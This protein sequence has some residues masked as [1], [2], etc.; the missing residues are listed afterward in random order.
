MRIFLICT[1]AASF[2]AGARLCYIVATIFW[3][4]GDRLSAFVIGAAPLLVL[5]V[6]FVPNHPDME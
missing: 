4:E 2:L 5:A 3:I 1:L 6:L